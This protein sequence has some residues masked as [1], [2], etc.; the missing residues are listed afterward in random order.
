MDVT[1]LSAVE[2]A[3]AIR[4][5]RVSS[6]EVVEGVLARI[7]DMDGDLRAFVTV[8]RDGARAAARAADQKL[9]DDL[10][11]GVLHGVPFSVKDLLDTAGVRTTYGSMALAD[12]VPTADV[13]AV[14]RLRSAG[15]I[16]VG[17]TATPE[18][19]ASLC[20]RSALN[21]I[22]RNPWDPDRS[23]GGSSGGAGVAV[24]TG[25]GPI[26]VS[27]DGGGS[28]RI[29]ASACGV[30]GLKAT[31]GRIPHE[32]WPFHFD[33]NSSVSINARCVPDLAA[34]LD[35]MSG[36]HPLDPWSR[37]P[38]RELD[39]DGSDPRV[40]RVLFMPH[41]AGLTA[42]AE[43]LDKVETVL[44]SLEGT[45]V[46]IDRTDDDPTGHDPSMVT[47][48]LFANL[49]A[50]AREFT[51]DQQRLL[52]EP[53]RTAVTGDRVGQD[54]VAL[55]QC[56]LERS[57]IYNRVEDLFTRYDLIISPTV[58]AEPPLADRDD[59]IVVD[60]RE[61]PLM[62]WWSHLSLANMTGHPA[63]S[64][65]AGFTAGGLPV[66]IHAV[67]PWDGEPALLGFAEVI[68]GLHPWS[69]LWPPGVD[70]PPVE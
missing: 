12:N 61:V 18:F 10:E 2:L 24:A 47:R 26:A 8:D 58:M 65:P 28:A 22:T 60:G 34:M 19:A 64:V 43:V 30:L 53:F 57:R 51:P 69:H 13:E 66:G 14:A 6:V 48:I 54:A 32:S 33:N 56:S 11:V 39:G 27:T 49:V 46:V 5:R 23:P 1:R 42:D 38:P 36:P 17:K 20:T 9:I 40:G 35:I 44:A 29:P 21:G 55:Q 25:M 50:R 68:A 59:V 3:T 37:R 67:G 7:D 63:I 70:A 41:P 4:E 52:E 15:A 16:L 31:L 62:R 45:G